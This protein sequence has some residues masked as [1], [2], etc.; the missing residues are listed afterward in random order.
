M[1]KLTV[2]ASRAK[3]GELKNNAIRASAALMEYAINA[4]KTYERVQSLL[5]ELGDKTPTGDV[6]A[7][8]SGLSLLSAAESLEEGIDC[9]ERL[10]RIKLRGHRIG[11]LVNESCR[12]DA[13]EAVAVIRWNLVGFELRQLRKREPDTA[14]K[15]R[16]E[17]LAAMQA[18]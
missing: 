11:A 8:C 12:G 15:L 10:K 9:L 17:H 14:L 4:P 1:Q 16:L 6:A 13:S 5:L 3:D 2:F 7:I 18:P